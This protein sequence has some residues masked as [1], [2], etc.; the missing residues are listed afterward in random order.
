MCAAKI[1][2]EMIRVG[3]AIAIVLGIEP[4]A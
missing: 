3:T 1:A 4:P 2:N